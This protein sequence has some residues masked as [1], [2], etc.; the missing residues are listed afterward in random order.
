MSVGPVHDGIEPLD[1]LRLCL[2]I[3]AG[4]LRSD[5]A[6]HGAQLT[7]TDAD[8]D[9]LCQRQ[10]DRSDRSGQQSQADGLK[11]VHHTTV[12]YSPD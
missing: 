3:A 12:P 1:H 5:L 2:R 10:S 9:L 4:E 7:P 11:C 6:R 8:V